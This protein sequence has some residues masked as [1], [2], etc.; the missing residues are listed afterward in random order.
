MQV[1]S[2]A[3][4]I[5]FVRGSQEDDSLIITQSGAMPHATSRD[6]SSGDGTLDAR[7]LAR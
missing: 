7:A 1:Y 4:A 6:P 5:L 3:L 2:A